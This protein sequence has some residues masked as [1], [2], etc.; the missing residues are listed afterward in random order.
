MSDNT[1]MRSA[2]GD[3]RYA[4][5][6]G[7]A[8]AIGWGRTLLIVEI[9]ALIVI[10]A[11]TYGVFVPLDTPASTDFI[12]F[13]AAGRL[14][15][16]G[17]PALAYDPAQHRAMEQAVFGDAA[18]PYAYFFFY[19]PTF[20]VV[21]AI[22]ALIP[23][24]LGAFALWVMAS[25]ALF[26]AALQIILKDWRLTIAFLS[27]PAA[28][29]TVGI[30]QNALLTA[31][32]IGFGTYFVDRKPVLAGLL[33]GALIYKPHLAMMI[34]VA[35]L[36]G[37]HWRAF[38][39]M[40][41]SAFIAIAVSLAWFGL[42]AWQAFLTQAESATAS[43]VT[44][45]VGFAGLVSPFGAARLAGVNVVAADAIQIVVAL[46]AA[47]FV[48]LVWARGH[49]LPVR[50]LVL[51][52]A[53]LIAPP[54]I[55]FYDLLPAAIATAW[56]ID[57]CAPHRIPAVRKIRPCRDLVRADR[58][59]R[60]RH[61]LGRAARPDR[62]DL[63][64][65][66]GG[67]A[68]AE[69]MAGD[70]SMNRRRGAPRQRLADPRAGARLCDHRAGG[71]GGGAVDHG[72]AHLRPISA[73]RPADLARF[74]ELLRR[75]RSRRPQH[76]PLAYNELVH[77]NTEKQIY[78][79]AR[80]PYFGFYYPPVFQLVCAALAAVPFTLSYLLFLLITGAAYFWVLARRDPRSGADRGVG[81]VPGRVPYGGAGTE[82][83]PDHGAVRRRAPD[84]R[85]AADP[86]RAFY[87]ARC[88]TSR[89]SCCWCRWR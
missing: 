51:I 33:F 3:W 68:R 41:A 28:A 47:A 86:R 5:W 15:D 2:G 8:R 34:P 57:R 55:L 87:S 37:R 14:A 26:V 44:G 29:A 63:A 58:V 88:V 11:G 83:V 4:N 45:R 32:L 9:V 36:A 6:L 13:F 78:G 59:A 16:L 89:I 23:W 80:I 85:S 38:A 54:V 35:L 64:G 1:A 52:A 30:G 61:R 31:G 20:L 43:F 50:A 21:C 25:G 71:R 70:A 75:R 76:A 84:A 40:A 79:D 60:R 72:G 67:G 19:P 81:G 56:L 10:A 42:G 17:T 65:G 12:S 53:G 49:S 73:D 46:A 69:R 27:F 39:A 22:L 74:H 24:Y 66:A 62:D 82:F 48:A 7:R 18:L 77:E